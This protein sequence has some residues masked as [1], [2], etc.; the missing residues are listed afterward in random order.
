MKRKPK[1]IR[2]DVPNARIRRNVDVVV[3]KMI[4]DRAVK[5]NADNPKPPII[6]PIAD[7]R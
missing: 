1:S 7:A 4:L 5:K 3:L 6:R 2:E